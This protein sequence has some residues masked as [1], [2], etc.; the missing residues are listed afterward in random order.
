MNNQVTADLTGDK[1]LLRKFEH[2]GKKAGKRVLRKATRAGTAPLVKAAKRNAPKDS[3][4][5]KRDLTQK[6]KFYANSGT[7][8][9]I[10]GAKKRQDGKS[11]STWILHLVEEGTTG[12]IIRPKN[13]KALFFGA[14]DA[15]DSDDGEARVDLY[16]QVNHPGNK[17][18]HFLR[19]A[20]EQ[21][22]DTSAARFT[23]KFKT[24]I[25]AEAQK[26][27]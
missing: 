14:T 18:T 6:Q 13:K 16:R 17:G 8:V 3:G 11:R 4:D 12:H 5:L 22:Q 1:E 25:E 10:V 26:T 21:T 15:P 2:L 24:E 9:G 7:Q 20:A 27:S 23:E 19:K